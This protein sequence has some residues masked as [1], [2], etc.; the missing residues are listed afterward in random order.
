M[1]RNL[2]LSPIA[3]CLY[4]ALAGPLLAAPSA[5][6]D[7]T[8]PPAT[9]GD[10]A[11]ASSADACRNDL[12]SFS[13]QMDKDGYWVAGE[14]DS[15]GYP[16]GA[17]GIGMYGGI[18]NGMIDEFSAQV[19]QLPRGLAGTTCGPATRC[20]S[21]WPRRTS[22]RGMAYNSPARTYSSRRGCFTR[23]ICLICNTRRYRRS[24]C[25]NGT[26]APATD[27]R[28][29]SSRGFERRLPLRPVA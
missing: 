27:R 5:N 13:Q 7:T 10:T 12:K 25:N 17:A 15:L 28:R 1:P 22:S 8:T 4:F 19:A 24:T 14:G 21:S 3:T 20:A 2:H 16:V 11:P 6:A 23:A 26:M 29:R 18:Y 9:G